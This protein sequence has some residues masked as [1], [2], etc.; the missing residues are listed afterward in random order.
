M[1]VTCNKLAS[2]KSKFVL[3]FFAI[4]LISRFV[5][6]QPIQEISIAEDFRLNL[7][8][9]GLDIHDDTLYLIS[10]S[11][12][13]IFRFDARSLSTSRLNLPVEKRVIK[14]NKG[15]EDI[16]SIG[17]FEHYA[18]I[19]DESSSANKI[20]LIDLITGNQLP[21]NI[22]YHSLPASKNSDTGLEGI[23]INVE[24][25]LVYV[26][27]ERKDENEESSAHILAY[28]IES[29]RDTLHLTYFSNS[30]ISLID[31]NRYT[32][33]T[34]SE[35]GKQIYLIRSKYDRD[36]RKGKYYL[37]KISLDQYGGFPKSLFK[38]SSIEYRK[39]TQ[40]ILELKENLYPNLEGI[41]IYGNHFYL[42]SDNH[43]SSEANCSE[44]GKPTY[45]FRTEL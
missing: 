37:D 8:I 7:E 39:L 32:A 17:I 28:R 44:V 41:G 6:S 24:K 33:L 1:G 22:N 42:V 3:I 20:G 15:F 18:F 36:S 11:C 40:D 26:L 9:S 14:L 35:N 19:T 25:K 16:E 4:Y 30:E 5:F 27:Q 10:E 38:S 43:E 13:Y 34:L 31:Y 23:D 29:R 2:M 45:L 21:L 12:K